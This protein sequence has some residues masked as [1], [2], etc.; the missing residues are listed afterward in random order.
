MTSF[1]D[2]VIKRINRYIS[3]N[4]SSD[5]N[6]CPYY[7]LHRNDYQNYQEDNKYNNR[8]DYQEDIK[9]S[10]AKLI[11]EN[12]KYFTYEIERSTFD[13]ITNNNGRMKTLGYSHR[14]AYEIFEKYGVFMYVSD[15]RTYINS[16]G[17]V[18]YELQRL[19]CTYGIEK[20]TEEIAMYMK[21]NY[22]RKF[23]INVVCEQ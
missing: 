14:V 18:K 3:K 9:T 8:N 1:L 20:V 6:N 23:G 5:C 15:L 17:R 13:C 11:K 12:E 7:E 2:G 4:R 19:I 21:N 22:P 10:V 16:P